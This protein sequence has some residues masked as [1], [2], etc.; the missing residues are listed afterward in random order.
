MIGGD[1]KGR[2]GIFRIDARSGE[3]TPIAVP[4]AEADALS[5]EGLFWSPDGKRLYYHSQNGT[6]HERDLASGT[7]RVVHGGRPSPVSLTPPDGRL[8]PISLS[9]DGRWIASYR[10]EASGESAV[11]VLIP[12]DGGEPRDLLRVN[13]PERVNNSSMPW[14]PDGRAVLVRKMT[15]LGGGT[16]ELWLVPIDG[17][18]PRKLD[19][20]ANRVVPYAQGK[21][22]L[23]PD[24]RQ[25]AFVSGPPSSSEVW[26]LENFLPALKA[27]R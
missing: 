6:V 19:F 14:T 10:S 8:G 11:V 3:V 18:T 25:I 26:V 1:L 7:E 15:S 23:H 13:Q 9:P 16:S 4:I 17:T 5:Y 22:R 24:G 12:V 27:R 20:D 21:I 2:H